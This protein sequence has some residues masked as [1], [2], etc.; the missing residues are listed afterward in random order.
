[1]RFYVSTFPDAKILDLDHY[2]P[3]GTGPDG[4]VKGVTLRGCRLDVPL[5]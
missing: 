5:H 2:G 4:A 1:M 3:D